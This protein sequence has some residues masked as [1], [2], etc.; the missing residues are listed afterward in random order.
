MPHG[1]PSVTMN[2]VVHISNSSTKHGR[3]PAEEDIICTPRRPTPVTVP[4][5]GRMPAHPLTRISS[6]SQIRSC[7]TSSAEPSRETSNDSSPSR[8]AIVI[9]NVAAT[10]NKSTSVL[11]YTVFPWKP[12]S[13]IC[14][15]LPEKR[16][17]P[18]LP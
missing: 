5:V 10:F 3:G 8:L 13:E 1:K 12:S 11:V 17:W 18:D 16:Q 15:H 2:C 4:Y 7:T 14:Q 9:N 6:S